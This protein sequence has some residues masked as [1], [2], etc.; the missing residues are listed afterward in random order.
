[1]VFMIVTTLV[2]MVYNIGIFYENG[3]LLLLGFGMILFVLAIWL[4]VEA[5]V[6]FLRIRAELANEGRPSMIS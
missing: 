4:I 2:A 3:S 1:M 6:R 5:I